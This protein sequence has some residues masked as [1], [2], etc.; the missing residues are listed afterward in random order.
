MVGLLG[1][2]HAWLEEDAF[3]TL[4]SELHLVEVEEDT[5]RAHWCADEVVDVEAEVEPSH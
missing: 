4:A 2:Y 3:L 1:P 5:P